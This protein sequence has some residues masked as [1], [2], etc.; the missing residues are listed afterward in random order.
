VPR[1]AAT[2]FDFRSSGEFA[3]IT[4]NMEANF[5]EKG[6]IVEKPWGHE[7]IWAHTERYVGKVL[8][9]NKGESLSYQYH[10]VKD[11]TIRLLT[12]VL[13]MDVEL[14]GERQKLRLAPGECLHIVPGMKH[15]MT[16]IEDCDVLEVSTPELDDVVRLEDRYG[17]AGSGS[18][19]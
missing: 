16:A 8:H 17:R 6:R 7:I 5:I 13:E 2:G 10:V 14:A 12:G 1:W 4:A 9:I 11:E 18:A 15:R 19:K 3:I